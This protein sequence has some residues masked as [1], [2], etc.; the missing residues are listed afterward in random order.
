MFDA[1]CDVLSGT[2]ERCGR[3]DA[4]RQR[5]QDERPH[6][7]AGDPADGGFGA[8]RRLRLRSGALGVGRRVIRRLERTRR[9]RRRRGG[10]RRGAAGGGVCGGTHRA[11]VAKRA[12]PWRAGA[13]RDALRRVALC[14]RSWGCVARRP[15][16]VAMART[17]R[18]GEA[19]A[20][21][22][23]EVAQ[24]TCVVA[25]QRLL[26]RAAVVHVVQER[27]VDAAPVAEVD[28]RGRDRVWA[29]ALALL[30]SGSQRAA[31]VEAVIAALGGQADGAAP[32]ERVQ[33]L[34][35]VRVAVDGGRVERAGVGAGGAD[36]SPPAGAAVRLLA[37]R[38]QAAPGDLRAEQQAR[39]RPVMAEG[40]LRDLQPELP[41]LAGGRGRRAG[42]RRHAARARIR[43][44]GEEAL[45]EADQGLG[46]PAQQCVLPFPG[47]PWPIP[48]AQA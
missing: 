26:H 28:E 48:W 12:A 18:T 47:M 2:L 21:L 4:G 11:V 38:A 33:A 40:V 23:D 8:R 9:V 7:E 14:C 19:G 45:V 44:R 46:E 31:A 16:V 42:R 20:A 22:A 6:Q 32:G 25:Q 27:A 36:V 41:L 34:L 13:T 35:G 39:G 1:A 37:P 5:D 24:M 10:V 15:L 30:A 3:G 17:G 29:A 43:A